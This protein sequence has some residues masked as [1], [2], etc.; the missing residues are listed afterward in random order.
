MNGQKCECF[1]FPKYYLILMINLLISKTFTYSN[2][3]AN[4]H[5]TI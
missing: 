5:L 3:N 1:Y 4:H 2:T